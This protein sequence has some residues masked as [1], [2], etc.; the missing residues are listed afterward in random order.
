MLVKATIGGVDVSDYITGLDATP[1]GPGAVATARL[2]LDDE[3]GG[4]SILYGMECKV[5][6]TFNAAGAGIAPRGRL[7]GGIVANRDT[8]HI[9]NTRII[10]VDLQ[11][12]NVLL[13]RL[14]RDAQAAKAFSI[15]AGTFAA[16]VLQ[17]TQIIQQNGG[18]AVAQTID[19][20]SQVANLT[21][22][23]PA[24]T[25]EPGHTY[26][27]YLK[28]LAQKARE[29][30]PGLRPAFF[31]DTDRTFG[32]AESF[33]SAV[34]HFY[35]AALA[36]TPLYD[37]HTDPTGAEKQIYPPFKRS[38]EGAAVINRQQ[39]VF[40]DGLVATYAEADSGGDYPNPWINHGLTGN[41]GYWMGDPLSEG[42]V[43]GWA[44]AQNAV[45]GA[46][47]RTAYP[48]ET[49]SFR[50]EEHL[51]PGDVVT[52]TNDLEGI[53]AQTMR[54]VEAKWLFEENQVSPWMDITLGARVLRLGEEGEE[55]L[56]SPV[57]ADVTPP[58]VPT[59]A[60]SEAWVL[61]N[62]IDDASATAEVEVE[63]TLAEPGDM[64]HY[65]WRYR[66]PGEEWVQDITLAGDK[67]LVVPGLTPGATY[68]FEVEA[69]DLTGNGSGW[70][71]TE[72]LVAASL[73]PPTAL[74]VPTARMIQLNDQVIA[75]LEFTPPTTSGLTGYEWGIRPPND[76][77][78]YPFP[79]LA[80]DAVEGRMPGLAAGQTGYIVRIRALY[81]SGL[82]SAYVT[83][84]F[85]TIIF[86]A[87][88]PPS[89]D[90]DRHPDMDL[91]GWAVTD[92]TGAIVWALNSTDAAYTG[93]TSFEADAGAGEAG[94]LLSP[95]IA[96]VAGEPVV[97]RVAVERKSGSATAT[98]QV[99]VVYYD[100]TDTTTG[101][102]TLRS[103]SSTTT[104]WVASEA[105][106]TPPA[107]SVYKRYKYMVSTV[108]V[109]AMVV[110]FSS[111]IQ[112]NEV[113]GTHLAGTVT[114]SGTLDLTG[115][116]KVQG[117]TL[118]VNPSGNSFFDNLTI[119]NELA[120]NLFTAV[121]DAQME[122][123]NLFL[124]PVFLDNALYYNIHA[125][126]AT[127]TASGT[128]NVFLCNA[129]S[130]AITANLPS[131]AIGSI[132]RI[133]FTFKKTD[134]S[135]NAVTVDAASTE[136]IDGATTYVLGS[137]YKSVTIM[138]D[139]TNWVV[140]GSHP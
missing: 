37:Y 24:Q 55:I 23:M 42:D 16:Q 115:A 67:T 29:V 58:S 73:P 102:E 62:A 48:R 108:A 140:L 87:P 113:S 71:A 95:P 78:Y 126:T 15:T 120:T 93:K 125:K 19:A 106:L 94:Y 34:L 57:A 85:N 98:A 70:S 97:E 76:S 21:S 54:V 11:S 56:V 53:T 27:Y 47:Q 82:T 139:G 3:G 59:W 32:V 131:A 52:V 92:T 28:L 7:F 103:A 116:G 132:S 10:E 14:V 64:S 1:A 117:S 136:T 91:A 74:D 118:E 137:Q 30:D 26:G 99:D 12:Y 107:G 86:P 96:C 121:G 100:A 122:G 134:S 20:T 2:R 8:T 69:F 135:G 83:D 22:S 123:N 133:V 25:M 75:W 80:A 39:L 5:W 35:D 114:Y 111:P 65:I 129:T 128:E 88:G 45:R 13:A 61:S 4:L 41:K 63:A 43:E 127:F 51:L 89:A 124:G 38:M 105:K 36:A 68:E 81:E 112:S 49:I 18:G 84:T 50:V 40:G 17:L 130:G 31:I 110:L 119:N 72:S 109:A 6:C 66:V 33:G 9:I 101:D 138:S 60:A 79:A 90:D 77:K 44:N 46:V 104:S